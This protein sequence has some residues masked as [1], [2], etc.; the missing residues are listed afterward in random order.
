MAFG[1]KGD[2]DVHNRFVNELKLIVPAVSIGHD[3]S[4]IVFTRAGG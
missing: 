4:L 3:E 2:V 1:L